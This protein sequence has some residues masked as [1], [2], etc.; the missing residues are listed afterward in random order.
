MLST[1]LF[2]LNI[3]DIPHTPDTQLALHADDFAILFQSWRPE[4]FASRLNSALFQLLRYFN[5]WKLQVNIS[6]TELI[7]FTK[8][9]NP[10]NSKMPSYPGLTP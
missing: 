5:K 2:T 7:I 9:H 8:F 3:A 4:I 6:K 10:F 1:T